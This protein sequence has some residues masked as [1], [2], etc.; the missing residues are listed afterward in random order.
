MKWVFMILIT[1]YSAL[2]PRT[3]GQVIVFLRAAE[4]QLRISLA[5]DIGIVGMKI[6]LKLRVSRGAVYRCVLQ[7][8]RQRM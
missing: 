8:A 6:Q 5:Q 2:L 7:L 1:I 4:H 3:A